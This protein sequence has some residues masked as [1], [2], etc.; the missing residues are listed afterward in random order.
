MENTK[1]EVETKTAD[2]TVNTEQLEEI[3]SQLGD[4][5]E[6]CENLYNDYDQKR[7]QVN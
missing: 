6:A 2:I 7:I 5:L 1:A 3:R 4:L